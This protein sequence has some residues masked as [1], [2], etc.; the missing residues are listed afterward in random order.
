MTTIILV[1]IAVAVVGWLL[2]RKSN[3]VFHG[4]NGVMFDFTKMPNS[5][6]NKKKPSDHDGSKEP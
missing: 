3:D 5:N 1:S 4:G 6:F 2:L